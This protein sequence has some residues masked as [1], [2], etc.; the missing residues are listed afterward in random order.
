[1]RQFILGFALCLA[2]TQAWASPTTKANSVGGQQVLEIREAASTN[3][4]NLI[5]AKATNGAPSVTVPLD[6]AWEKLRVFV[7]VTYAANTY[8]TV[9]VS[10]SLDNTTYGTVQTRAIAAGVATLSDLSDRKA[11][12]AADKDFMTEYD[13]R[14]CVS[15]KITLG[16]DSTDVADLQAVAVR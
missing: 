11:L 15:V 4:L 10:C 13:V 5:E 9:A 6:A 1:M 2:T 12:A 3:K 7:F 8:V 16:G 14:G